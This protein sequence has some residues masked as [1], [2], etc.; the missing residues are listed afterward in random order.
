MNIKQ[1]IKKEQK[2]NEI[3]DNKNIKSFLSIK[4]L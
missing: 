2:M 1:I 3:K 4:L